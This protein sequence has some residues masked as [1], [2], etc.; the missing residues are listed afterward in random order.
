MIELVAAK[1]T[2]VVFCCGD[3]KPRRNA[4]G[5]ANRTMPWLAWPHPSPLSGQKVFRCRCFSHNQPGPCRCQGYLRLTG[6]FQMSEL[7]C[8]T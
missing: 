8:Y 5:H 2:P 6:R 7:E 3:V 4:F 1:Q